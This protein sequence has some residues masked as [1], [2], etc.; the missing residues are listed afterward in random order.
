MEKSVSLFKEDVTA[1]VGKNQTGNMYVVITVAPSHTHKEQ[2]VLNSLLEDPGCSP[3]RML[4]SWTL[5]ALPG[6][7]MKDRRP[8]QPHSL[9]ELP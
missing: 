6:G 8:L 3:G 2:T 4:L 7:A 5:A 1:L 9:L